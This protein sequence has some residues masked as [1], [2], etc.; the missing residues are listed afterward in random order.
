MVHGAH[1]TEQPGASWIDIDN[2]CSIILLLR[3]LWMTDIH[4]T[5]NKINI[6]QIDGKMNIVECVEN[7]NYYS[8]FI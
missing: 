8:R 2:E 5:T 3:R 4:L 6:K 1:F 7:M